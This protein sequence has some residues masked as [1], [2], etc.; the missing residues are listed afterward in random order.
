MILYSL[1][2]CITFLAAVE[3]ALLTAISSNSPLLRCTV[4][5]IANNILKSFTLTY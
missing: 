3:V 4:T 1:Y 5:L 2:L